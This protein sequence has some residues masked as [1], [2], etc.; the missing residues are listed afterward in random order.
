L[1]PGAGI[2]YAIDY[3]WH[4]AGLQADGFTAINLS[5][6]LPIKLTK[7]AVLTPYIAGNLPV[8]AL[9]D[10]GEDAIVFGGVKLSV[11]F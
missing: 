9:D 1:V 7:N 10:A 5:L 3:S 4:V 6:A 2:G 11:S 8:D